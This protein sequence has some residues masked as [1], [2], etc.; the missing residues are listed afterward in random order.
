MQRSFLG[1]HVP[2]I[3]STSKPGSKD[4]EVSSQVAHV[5]TDEGDIQRKPENDKPNAGHRF[6]GNVAMPHCCAMLDQIQ[7]ITQECGVGMLEVP[8]DAKLTGHGIRSKVESFDEGP[9]LEIF[10]RK[11]PQ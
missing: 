11:S 4:H 10:E 6:W 8:D 3:K 2:L 5:D 7:Q 9:T 1:A